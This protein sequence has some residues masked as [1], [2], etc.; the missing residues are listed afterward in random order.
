MISGIEKHVRRQGDTLCGSVS[1]QNL[2]RIRM[3]AMLKGAVTDPA[4]DLGGPPEPEYCSAFRPYS[5]MASDAACSKRSI[6]NRSGAAKPK[7]KW[8]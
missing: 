6:G 3:N 8:T 2:V 7:D 5:V 1:D 4:D